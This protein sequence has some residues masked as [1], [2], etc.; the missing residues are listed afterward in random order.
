MKPIITALLTGCTLPCLFPA[1][2]DAA[3]TGKADRKPNVLFIVADQLRYDMLSCRGNRY[4]STP[5][6]DRLVGQGYNFG[7]TYTANTVS[8][9]SRFGLMTG[10]YASEVGTR[11][12]STLFDKDK[13]LAIARESSLGHL[14]TAAGYD[15]RYSGMTNLYGT[16]DM[17][18]YGFTL[19]G[20]DPYDGPMEY[21]EKFFAGRGD[22]EKPFFL[23]LAFMNPHDICYGA[24][25]DPRFPDKLSAKATSTTKIY[26]EKKDGMD[27]AEYLAQVPPKPA[28]ADPLPILEAKTKVTGTGYRDW[29]D[30][31]WGLYRWMYCRLIEHVDGQIGR[32]LAAIDRAGL[33]DNTII[34]FTSDHGEHCQSHG[35]VFKFFAL[36][37]A[38][39][40]PFI[41]SGP[42]IGSKGTD[43]SALVCNGVD[44]VPT[45]C[46]LAGVE[47]PASLCGVSLKPYLTGKGPKPRREY[48]FAESSCCYQVNDGRYKYTALEYKGNPEMLFDLAS[49]PGE[50]RNLAMAPQYAGVKERLKKA[51]MQRLEAR[52]LPLLDNYVVE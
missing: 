27:R 2:A 31:Q 8:M 50:T 12:N 7:R 16:K 37:E 9:P 39:R 30:E 34:V 41:F 22:S 35:L 11:T 28:N 44:F 45:I 38:Q 40:V 6:L 47:R 10:H 3:K 14:F 25:M 42:G 19:C 17:T 52:G 43:N 5:N 26:L 23:Y 4:L 48:I 15:T 33:T 18:E 21:A 20:T 32:I 24:G 49:D 51:L 1:A 36:E 46:D 13:V 29:N